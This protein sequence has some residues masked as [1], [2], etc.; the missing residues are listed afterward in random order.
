MLCASG[1]PHAG[2]ELEKRGFGN[3]ASAVRN[4]MPQY[5]PAHQKTRCTRFAAA[6]V[7][8]KMI[9]LR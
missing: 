3:S 9:G 2:S 6:D 1:W 8:G 7:N 5:D 4:G